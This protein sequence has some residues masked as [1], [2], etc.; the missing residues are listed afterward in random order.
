MSS[1]PGRGRLPAAR[2]AL[3]PTIWDGPPTGGSAACGAAAVLLGLMWAA[4]LST[5]GPGWQNVAA[6]L[7]VVTSARANLAAQTASYAVCSQR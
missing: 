5:L 7:V 1:P 4:R 6:W 2:T 3:L